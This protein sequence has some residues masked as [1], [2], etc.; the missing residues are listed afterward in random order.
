MG[1]PPPEDSRSYTFNFTIAGSRSKVL[2][3]L[4][5]WVDLGL[6]T[7]EQLRSIAEVYQL[8]PEE[9]ERGSAADAGIPVSETPVA[10]SPAV[11]A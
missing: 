10:S 2:Q 3:G 11:P 7:P 9:E 1:S 5:A 8:E 4:R 6:L